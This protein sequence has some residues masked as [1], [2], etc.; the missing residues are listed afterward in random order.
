MQEW[1]SRTQFHDLTRPLI[2][3]PVSRTWRGYGSTIFFELGKL[4]TTE[5]KRKDGTTSLY[6]R[7][8]ASVML[9]WSW[10]VERPQSVLF[11]S[12]SENRR[13][14][15]Q[16]N[17]LQGLTVLDVTTEGRLPE[18]VLQLSSGHWVHSFTTV[19][20]QQEWCLFLGHEPENPEDQ[21]HRWIDSA[22]AKLRLTTQESKK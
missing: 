2:G 5:R 20:S 12:D 22:R 7:G 18:L 19:E 13:I 9:E 15:Y 21:P 11:G 6:S 14:A 1:I 10:R 4:K 8:Q 16:L 17:K 3:L